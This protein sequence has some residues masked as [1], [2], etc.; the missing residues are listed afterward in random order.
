MSSDPQAILAAALHLS[1]EDRLALV[2]QLLESLP[3][4][5]QTLSA[6]APDLIA[7]LDRRFTDPDGAVPWSELQAED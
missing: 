5:T 6:D 3:A 1:Q 4:E 7:E 2:S